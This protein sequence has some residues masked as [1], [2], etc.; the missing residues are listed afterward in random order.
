MKHL[1]SVFAFFLFAFITSEAVAQPMLSQTEKDQL[2]ERHNYWR[3]QVGSPDVVWSDELAAYA[4]EWVE[5]LAE[6][7][8]S[9]QHRPRSGEYAQQY[10][11]NVFMSWGGNPTP[12]YVVDYWASEREYY[13][14]EAISQE[15]F[16]KIGHYTQVVWSRT[17]EIGC[18]KITCNGKEIWVCNYNPSGNYLGQKPYGNK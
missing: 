7:G 1:T 11:E 14:G 5:Y 13:N 18:A 2:V 6:N 3:S 8:C 4:Q 15:N 16:M 12:N 9:M 10:G 17:T